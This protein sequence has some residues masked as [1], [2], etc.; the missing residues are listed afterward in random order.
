MSSV[1]F[2]FCANFCVLGF[3]FLIFA[4]L[5]VLLSVF[6]AEIQLFITFSDSQ[7]KYSSDQLS[8]YSSSVSDAYRK[9]TLNP[10]NAFY[11]ISAN[12]SCSE[13]DELLS[14]YSWNTQTI[15][16][17]PYISQFSS[18][19]CPDYTKKDCYTT[20][21]RQLSLYSWKGRQ[22]CVSRISAFY[23]SPQCNEG[24]LQ[25]ANSLCVKASA[26]ST[27]NCPITKLQISSF[28]ENSSGNSS[29]ISLDFISNLSNNSFLYASRNYSGD[30]IVDLQVEINGIPCIYELE[31]PIRTEFQLLK[32]IPN[33]CLSYG[34][35]KDS[36]VEI[37]SQLEWDLY[38]QNQI[39][40]LTEDIKN[41]ESFA[42]NTARLFSVFRVKTSCFSS[43][44][45][46][47]AD[48]L[49]ETLKNLRF[50][51]D[52]LGII[53]V[54][55]TIIFWTIH[56]AGMV[57]RRV[58]VD[59][60]ILAFLVIVLVFIQAIICP[61]SLNYVSRSIGN[62]QYI[63]DVYKGKC[64]A[65]QGYNDMIKDLE[66]NVVVNTQKVYA[67]IN[68]ILYF[69]M[70]MFIVCIL[71]LMDKLKFNYFF[72]EEAQGYLEENDFG[73]LFKQVLNDIEC[74]CIL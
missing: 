62:N 20:S 56:V 49:I 43:F 15:C 64:F 51:G 32:A 26:N 9:S 52:A 54:V 39:P 3:L 27:M 22:F 36:Y 60:I 17:C 14:L 24:D 23:Q 50:G 40:R 4:Y 10:I 16:V 1:K 66:E 48:P 53:I 47:L 34:N 45:L 72:D 73:D 69:S 74:D 8:A 21:E 42:T 70:V 7:A 59:S 5:V 37:D 55:L 19:S 46:E 65:E 58:K 28:Y 29:G 35:D 30:F 41:I 38:T 57:Y 67:F 68:T 71:Y 11:T 44:K 6:S 2:E 61:I 63:Y 31:S 25:C 12:S 13:S 18:G 33:G